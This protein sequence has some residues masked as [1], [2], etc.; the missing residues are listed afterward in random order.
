M[1]EHQCPDVADVPKWRREANLRDSQRLDNAV[2]VYAQEHFGGS[3]DARVSSLEIQ[4]VRD[5]AHDDD[6]RF[7]VG[8][9][10]SR[11]R[12]LRCMYAS[13]AEAFDSVGIQAQSRLRRI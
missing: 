5:M 12:A 7:R 1:S 3:G 6:H 4:L 9:G 2:P 11:P 10:E 13:N 8:A